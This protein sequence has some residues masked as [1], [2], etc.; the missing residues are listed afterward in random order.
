MIDLSK[1]EDVKKLFERAE[2]KEHL[3]INRKVTW[4]ISFRDHEGEDSC[5]ILVDENKKCY[6]SRLSQRKIWIERERYCA[7]S[8]A[9]IKA[10]FFDCRGK[11]QQRFPYLFR[12]AV[13]IPI[14]GPNCNPDTLWFNLFQVCDLKKWLVNEA[15]SVLIMQ[16]GTEWLVPRH[17][18]PLRE[19]IEECVMEYLAF[20]DVLWNFDYADQPLSNAESKFQSTFLHEC[21]LRVLRRENIYSTEKLLLS[22]YER[23][24][25]GNRKPKWVMEAL[26]KEEKD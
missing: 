7:F 25:N 5:T 1:L 10:S 11:N 12:D 3:K 23:K 26:E 13:F 17:R 22:L 2:R 18:R 6:K 21:Y 14:D 8:R 19:Q 15:Y 16:D 20:A 4:V 9:I 24:V